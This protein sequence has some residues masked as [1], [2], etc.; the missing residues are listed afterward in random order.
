MY[1]VGRFV[2]A[3]WSHLALLTLL[4]ARSSLLFDFLIRCGL[5]F[6]LSRLRSSSNASRRSIASF[7]CWKALSIFLDM[8]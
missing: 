1:P 8:A 5:V 7:R 6:S 2:S 4:C 3:G